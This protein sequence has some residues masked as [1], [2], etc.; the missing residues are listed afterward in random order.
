MAGGGKLTPAEQALIDAAMA[1]GKLREVNPGHAIGAEPK[2][3]DL[4]KL[5][6]LRRR[7]PMH[8]MHSAVGRRSARKTRSA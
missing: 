6:E 1:N 7:G 5:E 4:H 2:G 8:S 3:S